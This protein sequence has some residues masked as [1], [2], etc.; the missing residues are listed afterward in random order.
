MV[1]DEIV[2]FGGT[3]LL[4]L[5]NGSVD[6]LLSVDFIACLFQL[7]C[8]SL[9]GQG[10]KTTTQPTRFPRLEKPIRRQPA[11]CPYDVYV[12]NMTRGPFKMS[13]RAVE[14]TNLCSGKDPPLFY[15]SNASH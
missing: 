3:A 5:F 11:H 9:I 10:Q 2:G 12:N 4:V 7:I 13:T 8:F 15:N 1:L 6:L 14:I